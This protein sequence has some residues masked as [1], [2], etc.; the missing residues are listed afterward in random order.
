MDGIPAAQH[1]GNAQRVA[2]ID[3]SNRDDLSSRQDSEM[4]RLST[5]A[6]EPSE[7]RTSELHEIKSFR[8]LLPQFEQPGPKPVFP[9]LDVSISKMVK[10]EDSK[11]P[12]TG[13]SGERRLLCY[14]HEPLVL[15][16]CGKRT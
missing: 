8:G 6:A 5:V 15:A 10:F 7:I 1:A 16:A 2:T 13:A 9:R 4:S 12:V 11:Q 14:F 3:A